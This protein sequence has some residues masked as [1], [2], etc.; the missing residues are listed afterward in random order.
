MTVAYCSRDFPLA[1]LHRLPQ[2]VVHDAQLGDLPDDPLLRGVDPRDPLS[3]LRVLDVAQP[4]PHQ[5]ADVELVVDQAGAPL[6]VAPDGRIGPELAR[7]AGD[8]FPV[9][10]PRDRTRACAGSELPEYP[11]HG[12]GLGF[13]DRAPAPYRIARAVE[14]LHHVVAVAEPAARTTLLDPAPEA[15]VGLRREVLQEQR[16]HRALE[17]DMELVDFAFRQGD[18]HHARELQV[19]V[20][21]RHVGLVAAHPVERLGDHDLEQAAPCVLQQCLDAGTEDHAGA[22]DGGVLVR[23]GDLPAL[24]RRAFTADPELV[25]DRGRPLLVGRVAGIERAAQGHGLRSP[26]S[27][28]HPFPAR[29]RWRRRACPVPRARCAGR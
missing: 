8:A 28:R 18:D 26:I 21:R 12:F 1:V 9:Q 24:A 10:P 29:C 23:A 15:P 4:V 22:G 6:R 25:L 11:A 27:R 16:I 17:T 5:P 7:G 13:V 2:R 20:E 14:R 19:L 3:R